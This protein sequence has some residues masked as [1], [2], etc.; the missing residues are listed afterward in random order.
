MNLPCNP[1]IPLLGIYPRELKVCAHAKICMQMFKVALFIIVVNWKQ[2]K[3]PL[4]DKWIKDCGTST[5]EDS[6][7]KRSKL[8]IHASTLINLKSIVVR[9]ESQALKGTHCMIPFT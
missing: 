7:V 6:A 1:G 5:V 9:A 8:L 4:A 2:S 3:C